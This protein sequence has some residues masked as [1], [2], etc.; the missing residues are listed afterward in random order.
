MKSKNLLGLEWLGSVPE[1]KVGMKRPQL[2]PSTTLQIS[3]LFQKEVVYSDNISPQKQ[4]QQPFSTA[5]YNSL[6]KSPINNQTLNNTFELSS[7]QNEQIVDT[8]LKRAFSSYKRRNHN[9]QKK[10]QWQN[11]RSKSKSFSYSE[12]FGELLIKPI[13]RVPIRSESRHS[14]NSDKDK[15]LLNDTE[16]SSN[17]ND[18]NINN[19]YNKILED[20][21]ITNSSINTKLIHSKNYKKIFFINNKINNYND[22]YQIEKNET[23]EKNQDVLDEVLDRMYIANHKE[24]KVIPPIQVVLEKPNISKIKKFVKMNSL[25]TTLLDKSKELNESNKKDEN[26]KIEMRIK[27][28]KIRRDAFNNP[29][30]ILENTLSYSNLEDSLHHQRSYPE[31]DLDSSSLKVS[32]HSIIAPNFIIKD[33]LKILGKNTPNH[34]RKKVYPSQIKKLIE[35]GINNSKLSSPKPKSLK[36]NGLNESEPLSK[37]QDI[38]KS[39]KIKNKSPMK[40]KSKILGSETEVK[41]S[42]FYYRKNL[43]SS[44]LKGSRVNV[45]TESEEKQSSPNKIN[46]SPIKNRDRNK[47]LT[48]FGSEYVDANFDTIIAPQLNY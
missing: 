39:K 11:S 31:L 47:T 8:S 41:L 6:K 10:S 20:Q 38:Y 44:L 43:H 1:I 14:N 28:A 12:S 21:S 4:E 25:Q 27:S 26:K 13:N 18:N 9:E 5:T 46:R 24:H 16:Y 19:Y 2:D 42:K 17:Q 33:D 48:S 7:S 3:S 36:Y 35:S 34:I 30:H 29:K 40:R 37:N 15:N 32:V 23:M 22:T 45:S